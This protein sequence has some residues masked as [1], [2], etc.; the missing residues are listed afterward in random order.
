MARGESAE[1][2]M[3]IE[4]KKEGELKVLCWIK[5]DDRESIS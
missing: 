5:D 3:V 1:K 4:E 2:E